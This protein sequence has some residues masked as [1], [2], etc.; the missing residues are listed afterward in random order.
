MEI[1]E[2]LEF[3]CELKLV[4]NFILLLVV[5]FQHKMVYLPGRSS[6]P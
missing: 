2:E 3:V 5:E 4:F 1:T 6:S